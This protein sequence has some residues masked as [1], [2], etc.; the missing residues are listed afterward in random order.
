MEIS[1]LIRE[2]THLIKDTLVDLNNR[3]V[4]EVHAG[5]SCELLEPS[6]DRVQANL[7][8]HHCLKFFVFC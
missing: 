6:V 2:N 1:L 8:T 4:C 3:R 7:K 5:L